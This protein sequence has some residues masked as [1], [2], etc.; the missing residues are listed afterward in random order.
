MPSGT[1]YLANISQAMMFKHE[2]TGQISDGMWENARP[3]DHYHFWCELDI[4][5]D[6]HN[7]RIERNMLSRWAPLK[8]NYAIHS[9]ALLNFVGA[10]TYSIALLSKF[11]GDDALAM[12]GSTLELLEG[13]M[14]QKGRSFILEYDKI[15][16][17]LDTAIER[18]TEYSNDN[19]I[20]SSY[21]D[22]RAFEATE[23]RDRLNAQWNDFLA[24]AYNYTWVNTMAD[25]KAIRSV[26]GSVLTYSEMWKRSKL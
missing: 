1:M 18:F 9:W 8:K 21:W 6:P 22:H 10:R 15:L 7:P 26:M 25:I 16:P 12:N 3:Y 5:I 17:S 23:L 4:A 20:S 11:L 13:A 24:V 19:N 14:V 2:F